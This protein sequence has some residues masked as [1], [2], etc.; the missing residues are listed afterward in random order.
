MKKFE[1]FWQKSMKSWRVE[2][3][4]LKS[5]IQTV[6]EFSNDIGTEF[7]VEKCA[8]LTM[9]KRKMAKINETALP[10]KTTVKGLKEGAVASI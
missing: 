3:K 1:D 10:N 2:L 7:G 8:V 9:K 4:S 5:L 6:R